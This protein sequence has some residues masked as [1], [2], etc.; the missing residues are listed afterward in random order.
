MPAF[1]G[2]KQSNQPDSTQQ[3]AGDYGDQPNGDGRDAEEQEWGEEFDE[4]ELPETFTN[5]PE[6]AKKKGKGKKRSKSQKKEGSTRGGRSRWTKEQDDVLREKF[7]LYQDTHSVYDL[8]ALEPVLEG[9]STAQ[10]R[11]RVKK[12]GLDK[13]APITTAAAEA[14][15]ETASEHEASDTESELSVQDRPQTVLFD[16]DD[17]EE[18]EDAPLRQP[19][20]QPQ[21]APPQKSLK[22]KQAQAK[23]KPKP[24]PERAEKEQH[25]D[26]ESLKFSDEESSDDDRWNDRRVFRPGYIPRGSNAKRLRKAKEVLPLLA[27]PGFSERSRGLEDSPPSAPAER[28]QDVSVSNREPVVARRLEDSDDDEL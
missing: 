1:R 17:D 11:R 15:M 8:L 28:S 22:R 16:S 12:L 14:S 7:L 6:G 4:A 23:P 25:S 26:A 21:R 10:L 27:S 18:D 24:K 2:C 13:D 19:Q 9:K 20:R 3:Q 5:I